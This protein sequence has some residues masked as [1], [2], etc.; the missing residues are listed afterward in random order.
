MARSIANLYQSFSA[1]RS[2]KISTS[3]ATENVTQSSH[4]TIRGRYSR[5][6]QPTCDLET[7]DCRWP[8]FRGP[9]L[10][11]TSDQAVNDMSSVAFVP[12][13][14]AELLYLYSSWQQLSVY[15]EELSSTVDAVIILE[16]TWNVPPHCNL[17]GVGHGQLGEQRSR[18]KRRW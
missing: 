7:L 13:S 8:N 9:R 6:H 11:Q 15:Y 14:N 1:F 5:C 18:I 10:L 17:N 2:D 12:A 4:G 16:T 3:S